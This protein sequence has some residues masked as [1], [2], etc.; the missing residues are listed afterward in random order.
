MVEE[1]YYYYWSKNLTH[2]GYFENNNFVTKP[3][4]YNC[5]N[6]RDIWVLTFLKCAT[7]T[8]L[9]S[10]VK[11]LLDLPLFRTKNK[12]LLFV[13]SGVW[14]FLILD[15]FGKLFITLVFSNIFWNF[16][17]HMKLETFSYEPYKFIFQDIC[18]FSVLWVFQ[19]NYF[20]NKTVDQ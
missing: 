1:N 13:P 11:K 2:V 18:S 7:N 17:L 20:Q 10:L 12:F 15:Y 19:K 16:K 3:L 4:T 8:N 14:L 6:I 9:Y 5:N